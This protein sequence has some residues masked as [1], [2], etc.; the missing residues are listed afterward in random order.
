MRV[1]KK[2][3]QYILHVFRM[4]FSN[5]PRFILS[6]CGLFIG[7]LILT[8]GNILIDSYY[9]KYMVKAEAFKE[10]AVSLK[11][12]QDNKLGDVLYKLNSGSCRQYTVSK[13]GECVYNEEYSNGFRL[14][15]NTYPIGVSG[16]D[17]MVCLDYDDELVIPSDA[18]LVSGRMI[19]EIDSAG[20]GKVAVID[21]F[22]A[23]LLFG[24]DDPIGKEI[25]LG[26][27]I[28]IY[29]PSKTVKVIGVFRNKRVTEICENEYRKFVE[30]GTKNVYLSSYIYIPYTT[31]KEWYGDVETSD[32]YMWVCPDCESRNKLVSNLDDIGAAYNHLYSEYRI[33]TYDVIRDELE[34][35]FAPVRVVVGVIYAIL[36]LISGINTMSTMFFSV[37]ERI[38]EIGIKKAMGATKSDIVLQFLLEG[39]IMSMVAALLAILC[40]FLLSGF[41][42]NILCSYLYV[43][44]DI[45]YNY[46]SVV[47]PFVVACMYGMVFSFLPSLYG[48]KISVTDSLRFE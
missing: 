6:V 5:I 29:E 28:D 25:T 23:G 8:V 43:T 19:S 3:M 38:G 44:F 7:I 17:S 31:L 46:Q 34:K 42:G 16:I 15:L 11:I 18:E 36:L 40:G 20:N 32:Y 10:N 12:N 4:V 37:K 26:T 45:V 1:L 22:T 35:D 21:T 2:N 13:I 24:D 39:I 47:L 30:H 27:T 9:H 14:V 41:I 33:Y 48:A